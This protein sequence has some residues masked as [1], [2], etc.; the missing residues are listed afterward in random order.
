MSYRPIVMDLFC[1]CGG[2]SI[3]LEKAGAEIKWASENWVSAAKTYQETHPKTFL[4]EEDALS[5]YSRVLNKEDGLPRRGEVDI[6]VG[7][8]PCQ[9]F[10]GFNRYRSPDDPRNSMVDLFLDFADTLRPRYIVMENVPGMLSM[11]EGKIVAEIMKTFPLLGYKASLAVLQA[12]YYGLPQNRWRVF[13]IAALEGEAFP[14]FPEPTHEFPRTTVFGATKYKNCIMHPPKEKDLFWLPK[15][16]VTVGDSISDL[17]AI[18]N[19]A[20]CN[21]LEYS[22]ASFSQYQESLRD[23]S[24]YVYDHV[25]PNHGGIMYQRI[26]AIPKRP[27]AGWISLPDSLKP[28]NLVR[29]GDERYPNRFGRLHWEGNFNTILT[30]PYPYWGR[31]IHPEQNRVLSVRE[32]ARAQGFSD[33]IRFAGSM[34]DQYKQIGNAVP[35]VLAESIGKEIIKVLHSNR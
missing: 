33:A 30:R 18:D 11:D 22:S 25:C 1:G 19:G 4:L 8:P 2:L 35:P 34:T 32:C 10:S 9:G 21:Q 16:T 29:H 13:I 17:P 5:L 12:G 26:C 6:L 28:K 20:R 31:F 3:G 7:G 23:G 24:K 15:N 14:A 27:G